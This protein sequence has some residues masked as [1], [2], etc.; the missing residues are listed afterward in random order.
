MNQR[1]A[2]DPWTES[3]HYWMGQ[4]LALAERARGEDEVPVGA[5]LVCEGQL[6]G[7]GW[8][9][10]IGLNDPTAHAEMVA[11][12]E[13]GNSKGN[14]RL[15]GCTMYVTLEP[16][17]MC[18]GAMVHARLERLVYGAS[19]P[20]TGAAGGCFDIL[21]DIRHNHLV[22]VRGGCRESESAELLKGFFREKRASA[23][24]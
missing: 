11:L 24:G 10:N 18:A 2:T 9:R 12:R 14:H 5:V 19:D 17:L 23:R 6:L 22:Q 7:R 21:A 4:A 16:C 1:V 13:A 3:D 8:N 15:P 20:K